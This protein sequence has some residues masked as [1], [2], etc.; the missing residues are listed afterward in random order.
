MFVIAAIA[1]HSHHIDYIVFAGI[2][3]IYLTR[4]LP[5][6]GLEGVLPVDMVVS[7][8]LSGRLVARYI[9]ILA[10][11]RGAHHPLA[12]AVGEQSG[13]HHVPHRLGVEHGVAVQTFPYI[14]E[15]YIDYT[16][17]SVALLADGRQF[18]YLDRFHLG[19]TCLYEDEV[20]ALAHI[21]AIELH[22]VVPIEVR[23][24]AAQ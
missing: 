8:R 18:H 12:L 1:D 17:L 3:H 6:F 16:A 15:A 2:L 10:H 21:F 14:P 22:R 4:S 5:V 11:H 20:T 9:L 23:R 7:E 13:G 19:D 24:I